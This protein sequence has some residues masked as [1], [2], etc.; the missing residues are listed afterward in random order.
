MVQIII[1][2]TVVGAAFFFAIGRIIKKLKQGK[3]SNACD[4]CGRDCSLKCK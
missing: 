3:S 2:I 1:V 4:G